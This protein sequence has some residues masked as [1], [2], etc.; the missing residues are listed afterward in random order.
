MRVML[1]I[2]L[3]GICASCVEYTP[4]PRGFYRIDIPEARYRDFSSDDIPYTFRISQFAAIELPP[5][6]M[7][8][9]WINLSYEALNAKIY[10]SYRQI[11]PETL[12]A[13]T[14]ECRKLLLRSAGNVNAIT[15][16][17]YENQDIRLF[18]T[19]FLTE[20]ESIS[21]IQFML[22]DS[23]SRFFRGALYYQCKMNTDSLAPVTGYL[24]KDVVELIQSFQWK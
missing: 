19:L 15:E 9:G 21:P 3:L 12:P 1:G 5:L 22:T 17:S 8:A 11:S 18:G 10:C 24:R 4:K 16:Q 20:G 14:G 23:V 13:V 6:E 7:P 2:L